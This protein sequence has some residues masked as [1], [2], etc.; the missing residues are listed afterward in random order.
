[1]VRL[2][3]LDQQTWN[4][5]STMASTLADFVPHMQNMPISEVVCIAQKHSTST[6][7]TH[8]TGSRTEVGMQFHRDDKH[9]TFQA[10]HDG[11]A[12]CAHNSQ[13]RDKPS[14]QQG[15]SRF[16]KPPYF[17]STSLQHFRY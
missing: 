2:D 10:Q 12:E 7:M 17:Y 4:P 11:S 6:A 9:A 1:M 15:S 13:A 8:L 14:M 16:V 3:L 5:S